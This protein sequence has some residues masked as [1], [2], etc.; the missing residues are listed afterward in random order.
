MDY[1]EQISAKLTEMINAIYGGEPVRAIQYAA[2]ACLIER[3][4]EKERCAKIAETPVG[5]K[6]PIS[7]C[8][9]MLAERMRES[10]IQ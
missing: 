7:Q 5:C 1:K 10:T 2:Q 3:A 8:G 6:D 4:H 9:P